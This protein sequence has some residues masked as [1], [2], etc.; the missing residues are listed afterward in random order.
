MIDEYVSAVSRFAD[1]LWAVG[2]PQQQL[3]KAMGLYGAAL[4]EPSEQ[5]WAH[6]YGHVS[7]LLQR[8]FNDRLDHGAARRLFT[9]LDDDFA[10]GILDLPVRTR[11]RELF[12]QQQRGI[13]S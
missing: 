11:L 9:F 7:E 3:G 1:D 5:T 4:F 2:V 10:R 13:A 8:W 6:F 12:L